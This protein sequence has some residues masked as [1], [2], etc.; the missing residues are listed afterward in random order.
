MQLLGLRVCLG[1]PCLELFRDSRL[2]LE[3]S[4]QRLALL[5][6]C[7]LR[8]SK[9]LLQLLGLRVCLGEPCLELFRDSRLLLELSLQRLA[10]LGNC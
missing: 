9:L 4:L 10:L 5:G 1:E 6:N 8:P 3:L 7:A 2:L